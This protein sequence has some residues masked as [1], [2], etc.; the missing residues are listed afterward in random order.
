MLLP[1][2]TLPQIRK[3]TLYSNKFGTLSV[4]DL[5][6]SIYFDLSG[7]ENCK[8]DFPEKTE[9]IIFTILGC[10]ILQTKV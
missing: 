6:V 1:M 2:R 7:R 8:N 3:K 9:E 4:F 10:V 5:I